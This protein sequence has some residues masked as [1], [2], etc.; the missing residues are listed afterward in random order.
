MLILETDREKQ[1]A[2][3][4]ERVPWPKR[5]SKEAAD[6]EPWNNQ[7]APTLWAHEPK[8][9][10]KTRPCTSCTKYEKGSPM[11]KAKFS[12]SFFWV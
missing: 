11:E 3:V 6:K 7:R 1:C 9:S 4:T 5:G 2:V 12:N 10:K 8:Y